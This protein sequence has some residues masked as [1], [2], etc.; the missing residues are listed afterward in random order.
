MKHQKDSRV[1]QDGIGSDCRAK[2]MII[3]DS[4]SFVDALYMNTFIRMGLNKDP[5]PCTE[6]IHY[7]KTSV[8]DLKTSISFKKGRV[9]RTS[10]CVIV[11]VKSTF[12]AS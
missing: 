4:G 11:E 9:S 10:Q 12:Q 6:S 1:I 7:K 5:S 2:R 3:I 8:I